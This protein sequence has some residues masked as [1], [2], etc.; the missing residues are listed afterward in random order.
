MAVNRYYRI[1]K[2]IKYRRY[3]TKKKTLIMILVTWFYS[4]C[5]L[6]IYVLLGNKMVFHPSKVF[7][8]IPIKNSAFL[9]YGI[10]LYTGIPACVIIYSY[11][12]I[13]TTVRHHNSNFHHSG[14]LIS[15]VNVEEVKVAR[16]ILVI[17]VF[18][19]LC[20]IFNLHNWLF[21]H[22]FSK[23]DLPSRSLYR[24]HVFGGSKQRFESLHLR[25]AQQEFW[26]ELSECTTLL[27]LPFSGCRR[28]IGSASKSECCSHWA[29]ALIKRYCWKRISNLSYVTFSFFYL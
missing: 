2:P 9:A 7:S 10:P 20:W 21:G 28:T 19:N 29:I 17:V 25:R 6:L 3:F 26:H 18:F 16:T 11:L 15:T 14:N 23:M 13:F 24:I 27:M 5:A 22:D 8:C 4:L 12:R 1:I